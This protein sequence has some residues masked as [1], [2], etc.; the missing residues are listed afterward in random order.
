MTLRDS[1]TA[2]LPPGIGNGNGG[3]A[4]GRPEK[5]PSRSES[6][7]EQLDGLT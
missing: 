3:D 2:I 5:I 7:T 4:I 1:G 6:D